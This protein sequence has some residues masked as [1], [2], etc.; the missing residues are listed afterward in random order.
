MTVVVK[1]FFADWCIP[2]KLLTPILDEVSQEFPS[3]SFEKIDVEKDI[4]TT[5]DYDIR[6]LP[7][8]LIFKSNEEVARLSGVKPITVYKK[9]IAEAL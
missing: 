2:C 9:A 6:N 8:V 3:V 5:T 1:K 7:T 4:K